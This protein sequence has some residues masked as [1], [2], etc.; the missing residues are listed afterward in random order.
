MS[1]SK[2]SIGGPASMQNRCRGLLLILVTALLV[3]RP[4][5]PGEDAGMLISLTNAAGPVLVFLWLLALVIWAVGFLM[6]G[7]GSWRI[8]WVELALLALILLHFVGARFVAS[9]RHAA[10]LVAWEWTALGVVLF[11]MRQLTSDRRLVLAALLAT[12]HTVHA[13]LDADRRPR[14]LPDRIRTVL[15]STGESE[16]ES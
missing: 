1:H 13:S 6:P 16:T 2:H 10:W 11:L 8:G 14:R 12:G 15:M 4:L 3:A 7:G 9:Y 5:L